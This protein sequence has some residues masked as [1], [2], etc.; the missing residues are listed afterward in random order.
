MDWSQ[1]LVDPRLRMLLAMTVFVSV[2]GLGVRVDQVDQVS[3]VLESAPS[4]GP[5]R[6]L[7]SGHLSR[8]VG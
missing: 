4:Y 3:L 5:S 2:I 7:K 6:S 8:S 1:T